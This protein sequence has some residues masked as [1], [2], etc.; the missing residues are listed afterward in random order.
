MTEPLPPAA[1]AD[2]GLPPLRTDLH[3]RI[4]EPPDSVDVLANIEDYT[5]GTEFG[6]VAGRVQPRPHVPTAR[7]RRMA[8]MFIDPADDGLQPGSV[9]PPELEGDFQ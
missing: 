5:T 1:G 3:T 9:A 6:G 2:I 8:I 7:E 4:V